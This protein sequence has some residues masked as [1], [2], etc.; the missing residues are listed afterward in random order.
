MLRCRERESEPAA[1]GESRL[2]G[3]T[4]TNHPSATTRA[5]RSRKL[6]ESGRK[7]GFGFWLTSGERGEKR[8]TRGCV[9]SLVRE[10]ALSPEQI[11]QQRGG[12][13]FSGSLVEPRPFR[14]SALDAE[15]QQPVPSGREK[16]TKK[17][18]QKKRKRRTFD[19]SVSTLFYF[20]RISFIQAVVTGLNACRL[21]TRKFCRRCVGFNSCRKSNQKITHSSFFLTLISSVIN[22]PPPHIDT[23]TPASV[24]ASSTFFFL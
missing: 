10:D 11:E 6:P 12:P 24:S 18:T 22:Y 14:R 17:H 21:N 5:A 3:E 7:K 8:E 16:K 15:T 19:I 13:D 9:L 1:E 23:Y 20:A 4:K 2:W